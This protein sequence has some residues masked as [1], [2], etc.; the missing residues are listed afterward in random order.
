MLR[1]KGLRKLEDQERN[2]LQEKE[3]KKDEGLDVASL[4]T[5]Y[6]IIDWETQIQGNK[7]KYQIKRADGSIKHY[8]LF[9]AMLYDF[10]RQDVFDLFRLVKE[11]FQT[12][13]LERY[14]LLLWGD[15]KTMMEPN[16]EDEI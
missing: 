9:S 5:R 15:L 12:E 6:P 13:S 1:L 10:D 2:P 3:E 4:A 14:D 7:Y 11:R 16:A 8:N